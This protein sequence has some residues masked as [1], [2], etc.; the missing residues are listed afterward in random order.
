MVRGLLKGV[1]VGYLLASGG[2]SL[3]VCSTFP[4]VFASSE[5]C[6][7]VGGQRGK[8]ERDSIL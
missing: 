7:L 3:G 8:C 5:P 6:N 1:K 4:K 2:R